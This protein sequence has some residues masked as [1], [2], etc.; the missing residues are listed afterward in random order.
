MFKVNNK[1]YGVVLLSLLLTLNVFPYTVSIVY[2][3]HVK[4]VPVIIYLFKANNRSIRRIHEIWSK[5]TIKT[6]EQRHWRRPVVFVNFEQISHI[7]LVFALLNL[8]K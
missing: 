4:T 6:T 1:D 8:N 3:E 5:L 2:F 7:V